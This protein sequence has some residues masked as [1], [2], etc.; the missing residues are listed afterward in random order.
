MH[1][2]PVIGERPGDPFADGV[3]PLVGTTLHCGYEIRGEKIQTPEA[4]RVLKEPSNPEIA[5]R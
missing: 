1:A 4:S 5:L 3:T 2:Q